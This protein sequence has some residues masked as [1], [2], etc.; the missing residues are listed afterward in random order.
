MNILKLSLLIRIYRLDLGQPVLSGHQQIDQIL[1]VFFDSIGLYVL[2]GTG[3]E[4][5]K[6]LIV[7]VYLFGDVCQLFVDIRYFSAR[8]F[9]F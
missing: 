7:Q 5:L 4:I 8:S 1:N 3:L 2:R 6:L 9:I